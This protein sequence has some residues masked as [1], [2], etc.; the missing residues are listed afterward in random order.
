[1]GGGHAL[2]AQAPA[3][4]GP[5]PAGPQ[6]NAGVRGPQSPPASTPT[7]AD[8]IPPPQRSPLY[9][10]PDVKLAPMEATD[11]RFPIN[12]PAALRLSDAR[13]LIVAAAQ[14]SVWVAEAELA[15]AR[16]LWV[17]TLNIGFDYIR[18]DGGGPDFNKGILTS[19]STNFFYGGVGLTGAPLGVIFTTDAVFEPLIARQMLN[20][21]HWGIQSAKN[22][23]LLMTADAYFQVH[24]YRGIYAGTLYC[25]ER[26]HELVETV[27]GLSRDLVPEFEV[28][29][30]RNMVADIEQ[31]AVTGRQ[32]WRIQSANLTRVLR[33]DPRAVLEPLEPDHMQITLVEPGRTLEE[34]MPIA[35]TNRPE[36]AARQAIV[37]AATAGIRRE[38]MRPFLPNVA[39]NG[40]Q[41]PLE[42]FQAGIFGFGPNNRM[43]QWTG[44][45]DVSIQ[46]VWQLANC[47]FGNLAMIKRQRGM[48]SL[49]MID[50]FNSQDAAAADV[51]RALA[52]VQSA[53][54]R[55]V[56]ADRSLRTGIIAF[57][58]SLEGLKETS[59]FADLLVPITRP[60]EAVYSL[61]LVRVAFE[62]YYSTIAEYNRA[63]FDLFHALGYP[64]A[65]VALK[66]PAGWGKPVDM[67][68]PAFLPPVGHGPPPATR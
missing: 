23:A 29:R 50:L 24:Q 28:E 10:P 36:I 60:Q 16:V 11:L 37:Q 32:E 68:R 62:E 9:A 46:P 13:P 59:R 14:A 7:P 51:T 1:M 8:G 21:S 58:G 56:Q 65:E 15:Q 67:T 19:V 42:M 39:L 44:R 34:L 63:Q 2:R 31:R 4:P 12:L 35:L 17:P 18:H 64:A 57:N 33:L 41:T 48:Q 49:A 40:F 53:A 55:V 30:A 47:G 26:G 52:R 3:S 66:Q 54:I 61:E 38:K 6:S 20:A 22:D 27:A 43:N 45:D 5:R 25:V